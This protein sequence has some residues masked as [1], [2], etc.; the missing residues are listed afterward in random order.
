[1][2]SQSRRELALVLAWASVPTVLFLDKP[3]HM[4]EAWFMA[5]ARR[6]AEAP[7]DPLGFSINLYGRTAPASEHHAYGLIVAYLMAPGAALAGTRDW[8][9]RL[10]YLPVELAAAGFLYAFAARFLKKPLVPVLLV[11][12]APMYW[13]NVHLLT[14]ERWVAAFGFA[15]LYAAARAE[16]EG[17]GWLAASAAAFAAATASKYTALVLAVPAAAILYGAGVPPI[18]LAFWAAGA[19]SPALAAGAATVFGG[20][21]GGR[22]A[23][24][25]S[26]DGAAATWRH[27]LHR[28]R[29]VTALLGGGTAFLALWPW[30]NA[31]REARA[32]LAAGVLGAALFLPW[33]DLAPVRSLD[34]WLGAALSAGA[35]MALASCAGAWRAPHGFVWASWLGAVVGL[36]V[37]Y[38]S[39]VTR[40]LLF[41]VP[42]LVFALA[43]AAERRGRSLPFAAAA[44]VLLFGLG[45]GSVDARYAHAQKD[46][47]ALVKERYLDAGRTVWYT[48]HWGFQHYMAQA[49]AQ[50]LEEVTGW[51]A[52]RPGEV[53]AVPTNNTNILKSPRPRLADI[54]RIAVEH[55]L[56]LRLMS[57][58]APEAGFYSSAFGFLPF[59]FSREPVDELTLIELR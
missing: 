14:A 4:D 50:A 56:P 51:D 15:G 32:I 29:A 27:G 13:M 19:A 25:V 57:A 17:R 38:W 42:P 22:V 53:I 47:A 43:S 5:L 55:P 7:L 41:A 31:K 2:N 34:R 3:F 10:L 16:K 23:L 6:A 52:A 11:L 39:V 8:L 40:S 20:Y 48:G 33:F 35:A 44:A 9:M 36:Q 58:G 54:H 30:L 45:L 59:S 21:A 1:M 24:Q 28:V 37:V 12:A 26:S 49:G 18:A 46:F